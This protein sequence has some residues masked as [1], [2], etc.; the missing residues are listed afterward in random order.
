MVTNDTGDSLVI[1]V[2]P[3]DLQKLIDD[4]QTSLTQAMQIM[5]NNLEQGQE[6][7]SEAQH[8]IHS[9]SLEQ[10]E[11]G[12]QVNS[13]ENISEEFIEHSEHVVSNQLEEMTRNAKNH[14]DSAESAIMSSINDMTGI[15]DS[16]REALE[17]QLTLQKNMTEEVV[18]NT[19]DALPAEQPLTTE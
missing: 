10:G 17:Q 5:S 14:I 15:V 7:I 6:L 1:S 9:Q 13:L 18:D 12:T 11:E 2:S 4:M 8:S 19:V 3:H 16:Q